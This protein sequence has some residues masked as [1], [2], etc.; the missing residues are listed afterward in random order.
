MKKGASYQM[1][2]INWRNRVYCAYSTHDEFKNILAVSFAVQRSR[3]LNFIVFGCTGH[4]EKFISVWLLSEETLC[5]LCSATI[6][7]ALALPVS[8][9]S[10]VL[11]IKIFCQSSHELGAIVTLCIYPVFSVLFFSDDYPL[12]FDH[13]KTVLL[14]SVFL[15]LY[16]TSLGHKTCKKKKIQNMH[17][18]YTFQRMYQFYISLSWMGGVAPLT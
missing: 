10:H 12:V 18:Q 15:L 4:D 3:E 1:I 17:N 9:I 16:F 7:S 2:R 5:A 14:S 13:D 6:L 8:M 11:I